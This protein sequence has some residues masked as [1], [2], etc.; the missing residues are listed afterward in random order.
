MKECSICI[1]HYNNRSTVRAS[2]ESILQQINDDFE[3]I[4]VDN[5]STDGSREIL[6]EYEAKGKIQ[7]IEKRCS[8]GLGRNIAYESSNGRYIL[9]NLDMDDI[10]LPK[11]SVLLDNYRRLAEGYVLRIIQSTPVGWHGTN[12]ATTISTRE[13]IRRI[14]TWKDIN[15]SEDWDLWH[16]ASKLGL[17][18]WAE[19]DIIEKANEHFE[20]KGFPAYLINRYRRMVCMTKVGKK[21]EDLNEFTL[22]Y[23]LIYLA[24]RASVPYVWH[25]DSSFRALSKDYK[26]QKFAS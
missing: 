6:K 17:Y 19:F 8:R 15:W 24:A 2:L 14:G 12:T 18:R 10:F 22:L 7:L 9:S 5:L 4:I 11:I 1:T 16:R 3:V 20:R 26:I 21:P 23:R 25:L 13:S